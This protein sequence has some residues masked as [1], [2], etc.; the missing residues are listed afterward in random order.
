[1]KYKVGDKVK[2]K[3][4]R[5]VYPKFNNEVEEEL[6]KLNR[7][8]TIKEVQKYS[9]YTKEMKLYKYSYYTKEMKLYKWKD[10]M[11]ECLVEDYKEPEPIRTRWEIL[12]I[13]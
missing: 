9:Y 11:I 2:I 1:M 13:R 12:D 6:E 5:D 8:L 7:I 4:Q 3:D 10:N